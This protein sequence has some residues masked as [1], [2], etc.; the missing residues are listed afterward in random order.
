MTH[1]ARGHRRI[2]QFAAIGHAF[3]DQM[4]HDLGCPDHR[5]LSRFCDQRISS[6]ISAR[7]A[8]PIS[9]AKIPARIMTAIGWRAA[10][11]R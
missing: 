4:L 7:R 10:A 9:M 3:L 2:G 5:N 1:S 8:K 11:R 6:C